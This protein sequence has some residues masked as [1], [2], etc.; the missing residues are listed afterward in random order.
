MIIVVVNGYE[1]GCDPWR[2]E[3]TDRLCL[4]GCRLLD[5]D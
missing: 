1:I 5:C 2:N 4:L 3:T